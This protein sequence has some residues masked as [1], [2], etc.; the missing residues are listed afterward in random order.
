MN[1]WV[2]A[3]QRFVCMNN[4]HRSN[5]CRS[6]I[7]DLVLIVFIKMWHQFSIGMWKWN[8]FPTGMKWNQTNERPPHLTDRY[9][10]R[11]QSKGTKLKKKTVLIGSMLRKFGGIRKHSMKPKKKKQKHKKARPVTATFEGCLY[12]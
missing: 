5:W 3:D 2:L 7:N 12:I 10:W 6:S 9:M 11:D 4:K 1:F 8:S